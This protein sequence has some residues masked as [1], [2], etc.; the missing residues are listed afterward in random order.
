[1]TCT[2]A[3]DIMPVQLR[4]VRFFPFD[5]PAPPGPRAA[6]KPLLTLT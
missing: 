2:Y 5:A 4:P 6:P 3:A 1:M